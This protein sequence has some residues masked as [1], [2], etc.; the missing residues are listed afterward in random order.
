M[1]RKTD[2]LFNK[3]L[4]N[5]KQVGVEITDLT[6][7]EIVAL[8][9]AV[10]NLRNPFTGVNLDVIGFPVVVAGTP[11][12]KLTV[13]A[14]VWLAEFAKKWWLDRGMAKA[15]FWAMVHACVH[16]REQGAFTCLTDQKTA[17]DAITKTALRFAAV[18]AELVDAVNQCLESR[19]TQP[20]SLS[21]KKGAANDAPQQQVDWASIVAR[22]EG[23]TGIPASEWCWNRSADY[24]LRVH[25]DIRRFA[26]MAGG[27]DTERMRD[28]ADMATSDLARLRADIK[29][30]V[31]KDRAKA[32]EGEGK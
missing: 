5:L 3:E 22:L 21:K 20:R 6:G 32:K 12:W 29:S 19:E 28:E 23:Q 26:Q 17:H 7:A 2:Y 16:A 14:T 8:V 13:G 31:E 30:R 11:L 27:R 10:E 25:E 24:A 4:A 9:K 1:E 18:E 15:Y